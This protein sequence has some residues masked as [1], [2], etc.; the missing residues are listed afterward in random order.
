MLAS[1]AEVARPAPKGGCVAAPALATWAKLELARI[2]TGWSV[3]DGKFAE[4]P[5]R[6]DD[7]EKTILGVTVN[8]DGSGLV[9]LLL[10]QPAVADRIELPQ[11]QR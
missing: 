7:G 11:R 4:V 8:Y 2:L 1:P 6:H 10:K 3:D 5:E 9:A